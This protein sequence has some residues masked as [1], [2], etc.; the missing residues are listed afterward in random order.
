MGVGALALTRSKP[1]APVKYINKQ[2]VLILCSRGVTA[3]FRHLMEDVRRLV[4][5]HKKDAKVS[6]AFAV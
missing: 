4:P 5:H 6:T 1:R 3:R 2:R